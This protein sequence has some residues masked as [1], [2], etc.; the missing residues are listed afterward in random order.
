MSL[1]AGQR[2]LARTKRNG[3]PYLARQHHLR[4][5]QLSAQLACI[6]SCARFPGHKVPVQPPVMH[7]R[8]APILANGP[9]GSYIAATTGQ[10]SNGK[11]HEVTGAY[12]WGEPCTRLCTASTSACCVL[13]GRT[14]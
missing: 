9:S 2:S 5:M 12:P 13:Q 1:K 4:T 3:L 14:R 6:A 8:G 7:R 11:Q 10:A